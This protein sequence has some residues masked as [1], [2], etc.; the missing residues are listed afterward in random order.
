[1]V[2]GIVSLAL[3]IPA[4][5]DPPPQATHRPRATSPVS[6]GAGGSTGS[7]LLKNARGAS[8]YGLLLVGG[9]A[10]SSL[11]IYDQ[12]S[13]T[14][15]SGNQRWELKTT[16]NGETVSVIFP[17]PLTTDKGLLVEVNGVGATGFVLYE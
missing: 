9:N 6:T 7:N 5:A 1:M 11:V 16:Q 13:E 8:V 4:L 15:A 14:G 12:T 2:A 10:P 3:A 17:S